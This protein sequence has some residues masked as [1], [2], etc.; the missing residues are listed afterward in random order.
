MGQAYSAFEFAAIKC[1]LSNSHSVGSILHRRA[2]DYRHVNPVIFPLPA[3]WNHF[4]PP[5]LHGRLPDGGTNGQSSFSA[6]RSP[7]LRVAR[8]GSPAAHSSSP[9]GHRNRGFH[10]P[11]SGRYHLDAGCD[12]AS[13]A[14]GRSAV[15]EL[16]PPYCS[17]S[18]RRISSP[19]HSSSATARASRHSAYALVAEANAAGS[20]AGKSVSASLRSSAA[21][22]ARSF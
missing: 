6:S 15:F 3:T 21:R 13:R 5:G 4:A 18:S 12:R 10:R 22:S 20:R 8:R 9:P 11:V 17:S 14:A 7:L 19:S 16:R 1:R 2:R